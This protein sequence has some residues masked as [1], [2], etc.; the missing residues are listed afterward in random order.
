MR[1]NTNNVRIVGRVCS[2]ISVFVFFAIVANQATA[3]LFFSDRAEPTDAASKLDALYKRYLAAGPDDARMCLVKAEEVIRLLKSDQEWSW[4]LMY[5]RLHCLENSLGNND[6]AAVYYVKA[7]YW[8]LIYLEK[9]RKLAVADQASKL[10]QLSEEQCDKCV[11]EFDRDN[12]DGKHAMY[13]RRLP[14]GATTPD[15]WLKLRYRGK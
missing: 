1:M 15:E 7:K 6:E 14:N 13:W 12:N 2:T 10:L 4:F 9:S 11:I 3:F 5:A 8:Y